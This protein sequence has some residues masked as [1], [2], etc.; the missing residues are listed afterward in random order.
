LR[1]EKSD[2][3]NCKEN[4]KIGIKKM[5]FYTYLLLPDLKSSLVVVVAAIADP[6]QPRQLFQVMVKRRS[7]SLRE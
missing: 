3:E 5:F 4:Q 7:K 2:V 6:G 1:F